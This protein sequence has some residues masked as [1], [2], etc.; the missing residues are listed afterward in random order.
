[1]GPYIQTYEET[2]YYFLQIVASFSQVTDSAKIVPF[3]CIF[4]N[5]TLFSYLFPRWSLG[6]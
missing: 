3:K 1:M 5:S 4:Q 6:V 2:A